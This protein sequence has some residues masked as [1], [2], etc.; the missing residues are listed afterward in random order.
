MFTF[1]VSACRL[2]ND[3]RDQVRTIEGALSELKVFLA[4]WVAQLCDI[5]RWSASPL[6]NMNECVSTM[7]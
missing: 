1:S 2:W 3:L 5:Y 4:L 6:M 7:S